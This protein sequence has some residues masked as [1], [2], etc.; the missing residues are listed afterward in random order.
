MIEKA[1][2]VLMRKALEVVEELKRNMILF[3]PMPVLNEQDKHD[4]YKEV[5]RRLDLYEA[6]CEKAT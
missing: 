2:P 1:S 3:V 6:E 5:E 4:L